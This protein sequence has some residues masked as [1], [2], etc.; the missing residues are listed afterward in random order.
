[1]K[2]CKKLCKYTKICTVCTDRCALHCHT[3]MNYFAGRSQAKVPT[4]TSPKKTPVGKF[5][6]ASHSRPHPYIMVLLLF[7]GDVV[8]PLS[9][10]V[11]PGKRFGPAAESF[12]PY[13]AAPCCPSFRPTTNQS[14]P[15][16]LLQID[17]VRT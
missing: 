9:P 13:S 3:P 1:M 5:Y 14:R 6:H 7:P 12:R 15:L 11:Y 16:G 10:Y 4:R 8:Q 2:L 17:S